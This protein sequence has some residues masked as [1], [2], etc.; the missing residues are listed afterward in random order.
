M[1]SFY[2][3]A[4]GALIV[5]SR[6]ASSLPPLINTELAAH[7]AV[8]A[9][10]VF[11]VIPEAQLEAAYFRAMQDKADSFPLTA[12]DLVQGYR[13][14]CESERSAPQIPQDK[15]LLAGDVCARCFG[16][17]WEQYREGSYANVRKC[18]HAV[19]SSEDDVSMF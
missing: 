16:T 11:G 8:W 14:N 2:D 9:E 1:L 15:N 4:V 18:D 5:K 3:R 12:S 7:I 6:V 17:G 10:I 19:E 13:A